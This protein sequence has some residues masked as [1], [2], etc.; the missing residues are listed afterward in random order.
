VVLPP[1][2]ARRRIEHQV[3][4]PDDHPRCLW[5][6]AAPAD[7]VHEP[8]LAA[9]HPHDAAAVDSLQPLVPVIEGDEHLPGQI[10]EAREAQMR[11][12][13]DRVADEE[14]PREVDPP[15]LPVVGDHVV[16][17]PLRAGP[18]G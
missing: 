10:R 16:G 18:G 9:G 1:G 11:L 12:G 13:V 15:E 8:Q 7:D 5:G 6:F 17:H 2:S 3:Q 4:R 14:P